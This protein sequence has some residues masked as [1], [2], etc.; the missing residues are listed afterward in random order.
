MA[1]LSVLARSTS[2]AVLRAADLDRARRFYTERLGLQVN[3]SHP[4]EEIRVL[5]GSGC[6]ICVYLR[7]QMPVPHNTV[8]CFEVDDIASAVAELRERGVV[9]EEYDMPDVGLKTVDGIAE[10]GGEKRAWFKDS[11]DNILV[12]RQR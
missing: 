10:M 3:D 5:A 8:A 2:G 1:E 7:P 12:L 11:E 9:F 6:V 4:G